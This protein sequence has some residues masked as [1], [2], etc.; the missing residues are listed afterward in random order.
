MQGRSHS[1]DAARVPLKG[2]VF[3]SN[4]SLSCVDSSQRWL[5]SFLTR[6]LHL[7]VL[8]PLRKTNKINPSGTT[9]S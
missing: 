1:V 6:T 4:Q 2:N 9:A 5:V 7:N 8:M 3:A